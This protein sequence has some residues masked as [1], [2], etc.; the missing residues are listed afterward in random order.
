MPRQFSLKALLGLLGVAAVA[1]AAGRVVLEYVRENPAAA[2]LI[3]VQGGAF[4]TIVAL[5]LY[6]VN[7]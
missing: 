4:A 6:G 5:F 3:V 7:R 1:S 2:P